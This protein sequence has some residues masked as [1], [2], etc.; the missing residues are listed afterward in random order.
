MS[1]LYLL[2]LLFFAG[3]FRTSGQ[4]GSLTP[5]FG[6]N[7]IQ[8]TAFFSNVNKYDEYVTEML[9]SANGD[10]FVV[11]IFTGHYTRIAKYLPDGRLDSSYGNAGLSDTL[12][13]DGTS[14]IL[15]GDRIILA[16]DDFT[17]VRYTANGM[18][19]STFGKNGKVT[20]D[21][22]RLWSDA[23]SIALHED[24][25]IVGGT[26]WNPVNNTSSFA[27]ARYS[28]NG[29]LDSSFGVNGKVITDFNNSG[30]WI[31]SIVLQGDKIIVNGSINNDFALARYSADGTLDASFG[32][33]GI[34]TDEFDVIAISLQG[35]KIVVA[36]YTFNEQIHSDFILARYT[37]N[38]RLDAS[39]G[40]NG[41]VITD[42]NGSDDYANA[43][44]IQGNHIIVAGSAFDSHFLHDDFALARYTA[45]G[46]L[47]FSFGENGKVTTDFNNKSNDNSNAIAF[48]EATL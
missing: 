43:I 27:L 44:V 14:A 11:S 30:S 10:I 31:N 25:I 8:T 13:L 39:F 28:A 21:F 20:T 26:T 45:D 46:K 36:G 16:G 24:K 18:L 6:N 4:A 37:A 9:T 15:Q 41:I 34:V 29:T 1:K 22:Q 23:S 40:E 12:N 47:D 19:D 17:L 5:T 32:E 38:G 3:I 2:L 7:G 35:N 42:F 33:N 48:R